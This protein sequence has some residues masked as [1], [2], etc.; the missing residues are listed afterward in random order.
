MSDVKDIQ[1]GNLH[2]R[3]RLWDTIGTDDE[4]LAGLDAAQR[5]EERPEDDGDGEGDDMF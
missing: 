4:E 5:I 2:E 3:P 1:I